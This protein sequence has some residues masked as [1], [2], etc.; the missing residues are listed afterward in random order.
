MMYLQH[1]SFP[2]TVLA[3]H[4]SRQHV[5]VILER[6]AMVYALESLQ[7]VAEITTPPNPKG[8][9][10]LT[11][12]R[13]T[14]FLA[15]P[16]SNTT[17]TVA[18]HPLPG[19]GGGS[20]SSALEISAHQTPL[21]ILAWSD[22]AALLATASTK[23]TV[24]RVFRMPHGD[25]AFTLRQVLSSPA[26][27]KA[28]AHHGKCT[29]S[30]HDFFFPMR[31]RRGTTP[32]RITSLAFTP[33]DCAIRA[34]CVA[35]DHASVHIFTLGR[36]RGG[37]G[38]GAVKSVLSNVIAPSISS[39]AQRPSA[40]VRLHCRKGAAV[41]CAVLGTS[42][43]GNEDAAEEGDGVRLAVA[44]AEGILYQYHVQGLGG[45]GGAGI[46]STLEGEWLMK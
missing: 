17:G 27:F 39:L 5:C 15:L 45:D 26:T 21:S 3:A 32:A 16:A 9:G 22:D 41:A 40:T 25:K 29:C 46:K 23:G 36:A 19:A 8:L 1:L 13:G 33:S 28:P 42:D 37:R 38:E 12:P 11:L 18:V 7:P 14:A 2:S 20:Q 4:L 24:V 35:S 44:T 30:A 6:R 34:L 31:C 43:A 10:A